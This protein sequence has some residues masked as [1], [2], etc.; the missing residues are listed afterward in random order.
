MAQTLSMVDE[1][2]PVLRSA[3]NPQYTTKTFS[4]FI[5]SG[6]IVHQIKQPKTEGT[7]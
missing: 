3:R 2:S 1:I 6:N 5:R 7:W 4:D